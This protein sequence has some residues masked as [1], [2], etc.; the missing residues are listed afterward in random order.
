MFAGRLGNIY[1]QVTFL[2]V[3]LDLGFVDQWIGLNDLRN[4]ND[5]G[6]TDKTAL[7]YLLLPEI[8][9]LYLSIINIF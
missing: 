3:T 5:F 6:W 1:S 9:K 7:V 8:L 4:E 2:L